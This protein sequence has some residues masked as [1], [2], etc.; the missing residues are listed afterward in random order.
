MIELRI[1]E[2]QDL[3]SITARSLSAYLQ[4]NGWNFQGT[5]GRYAR[6]YAQMD[7]DHR[8]TVAVPVFESLDD[9][10]ERIHDALEAIC[11]AEKRQPSD[12]LH[13]LAK[14]DNDSI[15]IES[16]NGHLHTPLTLSK[17]AGL[18]QAAHDLMSNS[19]RA[20]EADR[21]EN[22]IAAFKGNISSR[23]SSYL[24]SLTFA[25]NFHRGYQLTMY[26]PVSA[27]FDRHEESE[28]ITFANPFAR[29]VTQTLSQALVAV[30][31]A[32]SKSMQDERP[33]HFRHTIRRGVSANLCD[34]LSRLA[35]GGIGVSIDVRWSILHEPSIPSKRVAI[36]Y[37]HADMLRSAAATLRRSEPSLDERINCYV[38]RLERRPEEFDGRATLRAMRDGRNVRLSALFSQDDY[39]TVI[40]GFGKK[41]MLSLVGDVY[42][43]PR[44]LELHDPRHL[45]LMTQ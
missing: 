33:E 30:S 31:E 40:E 13:D 35:R 11:R 18:L 19:A 12:V 36:T 23:V 26:S 34:A 44:G 10:A 29:E 15:R 9:H 17:G 45:R 38:L 8:R 27:D 22:H 42:H 14:V 16:M 21:Q 41:Q 28:A 6:I 39:G 5:R 7:D 24:N 32:L 2:R 25:H 43:G 4:R 3:A 1:A 37:R 20:A